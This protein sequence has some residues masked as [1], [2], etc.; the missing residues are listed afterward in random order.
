MQ[1]IADSLGLSAQQ[2]HEMNPHVLHWCSPPSARGVLLYL[3]RGYAERLR[4][5][6]D[7]DR[8]KYTVSWYS[9]LVKTGDKLTTLS[10][11]F[12]VPLEAL[13]SINDIGE[14]SQLS[15]GR[16]LF[17]PIPIH[18]ATGQASA[19]AREGAENRRSGSAIESP[20]VRDRY[21]VRAGETL[22]GIARKFHVSVASICQ[23][24]H[25]DAGKLSEGRYLA[26]TA[27]AS[28]ST[29]TESTTSPGSLTNELSQR[30]NFQTEEKP[31]RDNHKQRIDSMLSLSRT[32]TNS[33]S[34]GYEKYRVGSGETL[35]AIARKLSVS[36]G[37]IVRWNGLEQNSPVIFAG[38]NLLYKRTRPGPARLFEPDTVFYKVCKGD[39]LTSLA[40]SFSV[41]VS[42][43]R[44]ANGFSDEPVLRIGELIR[45]P[46]TKRSSSQSAKAFIASGA[47]REAHL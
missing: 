15:V 12:K 19:V 23:W 31:S 5:L 28:G 2:F 34:E 17:I 30:R 29:A 10:R 11:E 1:A 7:Q 36:V 37:E 42:D 14:T 26:V 16:K 13:T 39:N 21:R 43:I 18:M 47:S 40:A 25:I 4:Q 35:F 3:P 32:L 46:V 27:P 44:C 45:I 20:V 38:Q 41:T 8:A 9:Y 22:S 33:F 24:N 6:L